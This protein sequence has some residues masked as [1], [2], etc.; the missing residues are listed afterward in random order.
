MLKEKVVRFGNL[1]L[2]A[3]VLD[4]SSGASGGTKEVQPE[5]AYGA[6]AINERDSELI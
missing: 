4:V 3:E 1:W 6:G 2:A 5:C